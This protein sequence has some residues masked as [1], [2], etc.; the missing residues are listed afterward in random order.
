MSRPTPDSPLAGLPVAMIDTETTGI[1]FAAGVHV[2]SIAVV[3]LEL[4]TDEEPRVVCDLKVRPPVSIPAEASAVHGITDADVADAPSWAE[5]RSELVPHLVGR[6]TAA[7]NAPY[8]YRVIAQEQARAGRPPLRW[9]WL[10]PLVWAKV[11]DRYEKGKRLV[12]VARRRGFMVDAHGAAADAMTA[13]LLM[14]ALLRD[15][16]RKPLGPCHIPRHLRTLEELVLWQRGE[17]LAQELDFARWAARQQRDVSEFPWHQ[18]EGLEPPSMPAAH[19]PTATCD[20]CGADIL[21]AVTSAGKRVPLDP[22]QI[23]VIAESDAGGAPEVCGR[24]GGAWVIG[25]QG[26]V[27]VKGYAVPADVRPDLPR[28][29]VRRTHFATCPH[30][31]KHR[32]AA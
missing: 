11:V 17:A 14:S 6:V 22:Q 7:F 9:P 27:L 4:G 10:D 23:D 18:L 12:D 20:S 13:A 1:D 28:R 8:D 32:R 31:D 26:A 16:W 15:G 5:V 29:T 2:V 3:H 21:W 24:G 19:V 30:A 25:Y